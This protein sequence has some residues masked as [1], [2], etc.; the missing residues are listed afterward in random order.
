MPRAIIITIIC[1]SIVPFVNAQTAN[2]SDFGK[3]N[4]TGDPAVYDQLLMGLK[5]RNSEECYKRFQNDFI[6]FDLNDVDLQ[7]ALSDDTY[8]KRLKMMATEIQLPYNDVVKKYIQVYTRPNAVMNRVLGLGQ[9]YFPMIET[10]LYKH[11]LPM[12]LKMLPVIESAMIARATSRAAAVGLWQFMLPTAKYYGLEINSFIDERQDPVKSTDAACRF[13]LDLYKIYGD[14]TLVI[15]AYNCGPGNVNKAIRR[16][17]NAKTY[18]DIWDYLPKETRGYVPAFIAA[19]YAYT[20]HKAHGLEPSPINIPLAVDT[21]NINR[22]MHLDQISTTL[23]VPT[24][25]IREL[26][27]QYVKDVVPATNSS[28]RIVLPQYA[29]TNFAT[30]Q[31]EIYAKDS[32]YLGKYLEIA[33]LKSDSNKI[34][35]SSSSSSPRTSYKV[36]SGDTLGRIALKYNVSVKQIQSWNAMKTTNLRIGQK[37]VIY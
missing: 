16:V 5:E 31:Q 19:S 15:A 13:L 8:A 23:G 3:I 14:W 9:Y 37:L 28:Y 32:I 27:P 26:N 18:W 20:F 29:A 17:P 22:M 6:S 10:A 35:A 11:G 7:G 1:L 12:E 2:T 34:T 33:N 24:D 4:L 21:V 36:K 25:V 30:A